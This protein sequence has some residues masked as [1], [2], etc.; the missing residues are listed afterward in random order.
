MNSATKAVLAAGLLLGATLPA[1]AAVTFDLIQTSYSVP[2][3][4]DSLDRGNVNG[5][6][7]V[8]DEAYASGYTIARE[9]GAGIRTVE[10]TE[11]LESISFNFGPERISDARFSFLPNPLSSFARSFQVVIDLVAAPFSLPTGRIFFRDTDVLVDFTL[12]G[13]TGSG[14]GGLIGT[15]NCVD[16]G[17]AFTTATVQSGGVTPTPVPEPASLT[18]FGM[19]LAGLGLIRRKRAA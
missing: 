3:D 17:C 11:A 8:T 5:R 12:A 2:N 1:S 14:L 13:A 16:D 4:P 10:Q 9:Q 6:L 19:G 7:V 15:G 18:L